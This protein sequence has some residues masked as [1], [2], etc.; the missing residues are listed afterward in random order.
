MLHSFLAFIIG[1]LWGVTACF[2]GALNILCI[3]K[4]LA[5]WAGFTSALGQG[6]MIFVV[7]V[8][9]KFQDA[10]LF[11]V[12]DL[13][14]YYLGDVWAIKSMSYLEKIIPRFKR[15]TGEKINQ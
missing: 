13:I 3:Q 15:S 2:I 7:Y 5:S 11:I 10:P 9:I 14:G 4:R 8:I 1:F 6:F 12:G